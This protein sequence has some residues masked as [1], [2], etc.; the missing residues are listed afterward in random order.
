[1]KFSKR[2]L[3]VCSLLMLSACGGGGSGSSAPVSPID[4]PLIIAPDFSGLQAEID[5]HPVANMA[6]M[7]G[8]KDGVLF[9]YE[10]GD[11]LTSDVVSVA[12]ATKLITGLGVWSLVEEAQLSMSDKPQDHIEFWTSS[13]QDQRSSVTLAQLMSFTSGFNNAPGLGMC[14][15]DADFTLLDCVTESY[16]GG[17]D[18]PPGQTFSYGPEHMQIA[19]LMAQQ[20]TG[21]EL[22]DSI[23]A[24]ILNPSGASVDMAFPDASG[25]NP[26][27]SGGL[28]SSADDYALIL[29]NLLSGD[30]L[31][32]L[33][34]FLS[35]QTAGVDVSHTPVAVEANTL[36]WHYGFG[37]WKECDFVPYQSSCDEAPI[38]SSPGAFGFLPWVDFEGEYWAVLAMQEPIGFGRTPSSD[39]VA[40]EQILQPMI[41]EALGR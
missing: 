35:D 27:Y 19:A 32:D 36:D 15:G 37:F 11:F 38:I 33:P 8:D 25:D 39:S 28:R 40:L 3:M 17:T 29:T 14:Q 26:M 20:A 23:R 18:T 6:F 22:Q 34:G 21:S 16:Q 30:L 12:S 7:V 24:N 10:K 2:V 9:A 31:Q 13:T 41:L 4:P 5:R 1:M